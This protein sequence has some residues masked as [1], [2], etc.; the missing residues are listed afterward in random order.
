MILI[1]IARIATA[2]VNAVA[3]YYGVNSS[4][5]AVTVAHV[6]RYR[7]AFRFLLPCLVFVNGHDE[8]PFFGALNVTTEVHAVCH[9][10]IGNLAGAFSI[11]AVGH[12]AVFFESTG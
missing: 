5:S 2:L 12:A 11:I 1:L 4:L 6:R 10:T 3:H 8:A 7:A 9:V